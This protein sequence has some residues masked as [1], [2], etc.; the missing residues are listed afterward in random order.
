[1]DNTKLEKVVND[2]AHHQASVRKRAARELGELGDLR[3]T[4]PLIDALKDG[5]AY[6][7]WAVARALGQ[8]GDPLA[9]SG[10]QLLLL[11]HALE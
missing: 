1:M 3:S 5:D 10:D 11:L 6:V 7:R 4:V 8:L 2:L 9:F